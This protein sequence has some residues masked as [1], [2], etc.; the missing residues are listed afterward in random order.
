VAALALAVSACDLVGVPAP[1]RVEAPADSAAGEIG[2]R[3]AGAGGAVLVVPATVNG[4]GPFDLIVDTGAT[5]TCLDDSLVRTLG[6]PD[7]RG[8]VGSGVG[9]GGAGRVRLVRV[10]SLRVGGAMAERLT[11][12]ALDLQAVRAAAPGAHG[13]LGLNFLRSFRVTLDF[14]RRVLRLEAP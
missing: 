11:A 10:D 9:I 8:M 13:L 4:Q 1:A 6:L 14:G 5:I 3:L 12:C 7:E 2:F